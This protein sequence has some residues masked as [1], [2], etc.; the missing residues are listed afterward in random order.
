MVALQ[1]RCAGGVRV[2]VLTR[3]E[4]IHA[5]WELGHKMGAM[6]GGGSPVGEGVKR[7][8]WGGMKLQDNITL[9]K[10]DYK[11]CLDLWLLRK[12]SK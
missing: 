5:C 9:H 10:L 12:L 1:V 11:N 2:R 3:H 4:D 6:Q 7:A 8:K